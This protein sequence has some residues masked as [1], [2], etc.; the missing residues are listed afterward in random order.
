MRELLIEPVAELLATLLYLLLAGVFAGV[1]FLAESASFAN[2][3][4]GHGSLG[5]WYGYMGLVALYV[6][7]YLIGYREVLAR[8]RAV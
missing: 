2:I 1:G 7:I 4:A 3:T 6:G 8:L 5:L